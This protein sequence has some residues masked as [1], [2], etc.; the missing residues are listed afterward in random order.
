[1]VDSRSDCG[2]RGRPERSE[3]HGS[4]LGR[5]RRAR[6]RDPHELD[7]GLRGSD[8]VNERLRAER[9]A[10]DRRRPGRELPLRP[11]PDESPDRVA[12]A[13]ELGGRCS[14]SRR[15][16][17]PPSFPALRRA[18]R[19]AGAFLERLL[20]DGPHKIANRIAPGLILAALIVDAALLMQVPTSFR[21]L[22][23]PELAILFF[24]A[25]ALGGSGSSSESSRATARRRRGG[26]GNGE[27]VLSSRFSAEH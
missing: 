10:G 8:R 18:Y 15:Q 3:V 2:L 4:K 25:A 17:R 16:R 19:R 24:L 12:P 23:Y 13:Q 27:E 20:I 6:V 11:R 9:V 14:R 22:G 26:S 5:L 7:E 21:I 1:M